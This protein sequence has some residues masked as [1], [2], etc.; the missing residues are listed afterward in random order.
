MS[1]RGG[2]RD[3][4]G[5]EQ[6]SPFQ[7]DVGNAEALVQFQTGGKVPQT[8]SYYAMTCWRRTNPDVPPPTSDSTPPRRWQLRS[9]GQ[10]SR[11]R[12]A[13]TQSTLD[14]DHAVW[15]DPGSLLRTAVERGGIAI[16]RAVRCHLANRSVNLIEQQANLGWIVDVLI[17]QRLRHDQAAGRIHRWSVIRL[18]VQPDNAPAHCF[19]EQLYQPDC[20]SQADVA[21]D[22]ACAT[23]GATSRHAWPPA[24]D[25]LRNL[26]AHAV[27][28]HVQRTR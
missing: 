24:T 1:L 14:G 18:T 16:I 4:L 22:A 26:Q 7:Q 12:A 17:G 25:R 20:S 27:D 3:V 5:V 9:A 23:S 21:L 8:P 19:G 11:G 6:L 28:Q 15:V 2:R 10:R 13:V